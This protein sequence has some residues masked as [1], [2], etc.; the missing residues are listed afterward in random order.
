MEKIVAGDNDATMTSLFLLCHD[1]GG[2]GYQLSRLSQE[3]LS[4]THRHIRDSMM[5]M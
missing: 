1:F 4:A 3:C 5:A 2:G